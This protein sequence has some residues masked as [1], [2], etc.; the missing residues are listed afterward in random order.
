MLKKKIKSK[1]NIK[2]FSKVDKLV[3]VIAKQTLNKT[4]IMK[5]TIIHG[6][7]RTSL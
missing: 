1:Q 4:S 2:K 3:V 7:R 6:D 5:Y